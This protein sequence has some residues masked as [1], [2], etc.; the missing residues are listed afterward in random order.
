[1]GRNKEASYANQA[2]KNELS[3]FGRQSDDLYKLLM[4]Q[5]QKSSGRSNQLYGDL[6]GGYKDMYSSGGAANPYWKQLAGGG[7]SD[8]DKARLR[9]SGY[10]EEFAKTGGWDD[11]RK[12]QFRDRAASTGRS[13]YANLK[14]ELGRTKAIQGGYAP[15]F[16]SQT[17]KLVREQARAS[18]EALR[19]AELGMADQIDRGR[20]WGTEGISGSERALQGL[21]SQNRIAGASGL[22]DSDRM[23]MGAL[24]GLGDLRTQSPAD[25]QYISALLQSL[26]LGTENRQQL[27]GQHMQ[28]NP[29][30]NWFQKY[31]MPIIGAAAGLGGSLISGGATNLG[32]LAS[33]GGYY[34]GN[35]QSDNP[36]YS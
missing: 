31:G 27:I 14:D 36:Y 9:G 28:Y 19:D 24:Q 18:D 21:L 13:I 2:N 23:R 15:G 8:A 35:K 3:R 32:G 26:G 6:Y 10:Y 34:Y 12:E 17:S 29:N 4:D 30:V 1:M 33:G 7:I 5:F 22:A 16:D 20:M 25:M 11:K